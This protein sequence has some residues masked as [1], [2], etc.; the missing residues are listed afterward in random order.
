[1]TV[2]ELRRQALEV[3]DGDPALRDLSERV[4]RLG[5]FRI[6]N[7]RLLFDIIRHPCIEG[8]ETKGM[9]SPGYFVVNQTYE[10]DP[11]R[12]TVQQ[13]GE[14][15]LDL[16]V[17]NIDGLVDQDVRLTVDG[18]ADEFEGMI[19]EDDVREWAMGEA[20]RIATVIA[21][22]KYPPAAVEDDA[23]LGRKWTA[24]VSDYIEEWKDR[25]VEL[26]AER[27]RADRDAE[28]KS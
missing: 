8:L 27:W 23:E 12:V 9:P 18:L 4:R 14:T 24:Y 13:V 5:N 1:M 3:I 10:F 7:E 2:E 19:G 11:K 15:Y 16:V 17:E 22:T 26:S 20:E 6:E 28:G 21:E 25:F